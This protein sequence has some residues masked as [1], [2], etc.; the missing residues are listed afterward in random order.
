MVC[1]DE[2]PFSCL[3]KLSI[4]FHEDYSTILKRLYSEED[5]RI[6]KIEDIKRLQKEIKDR[7]ELE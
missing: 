5:S 6:N 4:D 3:K 7:C 2:K 1:L